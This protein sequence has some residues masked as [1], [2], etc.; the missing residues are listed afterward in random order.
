MGNSTLLASSLCFMVKQSQLLVEDLMEHTISEH[1]SKV[2]SKSPP[3]SVQKN[4]L[5][6]KVKTERLN[7]S[8]KMANKLKDGSIQML[9]IKNQLWK[10]SLNCSH[11]HLKAK[12]SKSQNSEVSSSSDF[13][14]EYS[15]YRLHAKLADIETQ[16]KSIGC[17]LSTD[18]PLVHLVADPT[19]P[20]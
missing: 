15:F 9:I 16:M 18:T 19:G 8:A 2:L 10:S 12:K 13:D 1:Y 17:R 11:H 14:V 5:I 3:S 6:H 7:S 20:E 4:L